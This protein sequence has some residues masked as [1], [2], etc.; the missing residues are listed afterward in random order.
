MGGLRH[1]NAGSRGSGTRPGC[2]SL[3]WRCGTRAVPRGQVPVPWHPHTPQIRHK[4]SA[5]KA[6]ASRSR[7]STESQSAGRRWIFRPPSPHGVQLAILIQ[8]L[9][10]NQSAGLVS[11]VHDNGSHLHSSSEAQ[12]QPFETVA[13]S[14]PGSFYVTIAWIDIWFANDFAGT[15]GTSILAFTKLQNK[16]SC[17][18]AA[19]EGLNPDINEFYLFRG[20]SS[21]VADIEDGFDARVSQMRGYYGAGIYFASQACKSL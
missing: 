21:D 3:T 8:Q 17:Q 4:D 10:L 14:S 12:F 5:R 20:T 9:Y 11:F 19:L 18:P 16:T 6:L 7:P 2:S 15:P 1:P 13:A